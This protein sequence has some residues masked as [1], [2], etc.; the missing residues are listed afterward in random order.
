MGRI[1]RFELT[2]SGTTNQRSD[3]LSY[4]R[5]PVGH[6]VINK[7]GSQGTFGVKSGVAISCTEHIMPSLEFPNPV[8]QM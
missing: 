1:M 6:Y 7:S 3:Q 8:E 4:I 5:H 2:T